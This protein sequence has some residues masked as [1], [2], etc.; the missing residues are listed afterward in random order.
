VLQHNV[1][2]L[3]AR[4]AHQQLAASTDDVISCRTSLAELHDEAT[5]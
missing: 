3:T 5:R 2:E 4:T 1:A